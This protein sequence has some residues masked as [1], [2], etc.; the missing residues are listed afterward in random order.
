M[1][2]AGAFFTP[3]R[4]CARGIMEAA[5]KRE[6]AACRRQEEEFPM[7]ECLLEKFY[8][9]WYHELI[10]WCS[11]MAGD[12][13]L[14][15][16]LVQ[17]AN[18]I[19]H[20]G[21]YDINGSTAV[22]ENTFLSVNGNVIIKPGTGEVLSSYTAVSINGSVLCP[23]SLEPFLSRFS[24]N[25]STECYP[26]ACTVLDAVFTPDTWFP[27]RARQEAHYYV[28]EQLRLT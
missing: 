25:G 17:E 1:E 20:N 16:D 24:V 19:S 4:L 13:D 12:R 18:V 14:A 7:D 27:L 9:T 23:A 28:S 15:E 26:D 10:R 3:C 11:H 22:P 21:D 5:E 2:A 6:N 8:Q